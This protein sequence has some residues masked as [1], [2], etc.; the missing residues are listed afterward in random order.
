[1]ISI[2][3]TERDG[4]AKCRVKTRC[5]GKRALVRN[6]VGALG[7]IRQ[8]VKKYIPEMTPEELM[9]IARKAECDGSI[10]KVENKEG[11]L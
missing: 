8:M 7:A 10:I 3:I 9:E 5:I 2:K 4:I 1:M 6:I 11:L